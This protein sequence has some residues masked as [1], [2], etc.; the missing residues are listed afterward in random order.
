MQQVIA[1]LHIRDGSIRQIEWFAKPLANADGKLTAV[2]AIGQDITERQQAEERLAQFARAK[3]ILAGVDRRDCPPRRPAGTVEEICRVAV[4]AGGFKLAWVGMVSPEDRSAVA[5]AGTTGY[6]KGIRM[7]VKAGCTGRPR[8][9]G[10]SIRENR[11][12]VIEDI[13]RDSRMAPWHDRLRKFGLHYVGRV[14][15]PG[16]GKADRLFSCLC[17]ARRFL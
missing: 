9:G 1:P 17:A 7:S 4:E 14:S 6:L 10:Q 8:A 13:D 2:L 12:V 11:P 15:H 3:G 16:C 5:Q